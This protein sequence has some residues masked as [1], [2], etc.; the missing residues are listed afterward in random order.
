MIHIHASGH[1]IRDPQARTTKTGGEFVTCMLAVG[2][3]T[4]VNVAAFDPELCAILAKCKQGDGLSVAGK[5]TLSAYTAK[6]GATK[7][8]VSVTANRLL[9]AAAEGLAKPKPR[10]QRE[11]QAYGG[12]YPP[13][14]PAPFDDAVPF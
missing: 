10:P 14:G 5:A 9:T 2:D 7:P 1:L 8:S 3:D 6:D 11:H 13:N 12:S 4:V